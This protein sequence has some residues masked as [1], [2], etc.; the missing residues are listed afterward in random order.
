MNGLRYLIASSTLLVSGLSFGLDVSARSAIVIDASSGKVLWEKN[1][2][3]SMYPA[4]TTKIMTGLLL[5]EHCL[6]SDVITAPDDVETVKEASMH[7]RPGERVSAHDMLYAIMLRSANDGCYAIAKHVSG[8]VDAFAKLMNDRARQ[9]GCTNTHFHNPNGLNDSEHTTTAHDLALMARAAM[10]YPEF[11]EAVRTYKYEITRSI[12]MKDRVMV[13]HDKWLK[14]DPTADGVKTGYTVP[15]GHCFVGSATRNGFRVITVVMK[16]DHWQ[17]DHQQ[18]LNWAFKNF[19]KKEKFA[20]GSIVGTLKIPG[21]DQKPITVALSQ[22]A[23]TLGAVG[24]PVTLTESSVVPIRGLKA[25]VKRGERVGMLVLKDSD[26]WL[27]KIPVVAEADVKT[28][29]S[30]RATGNAIGSSYF[31]GGALFVGVVLVQGRKKRKI[32]N[33]G[34]TTTKQRF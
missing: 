23:Y 4:S 13:N 24:K 7:L 19:E 3:S 10:M 25:P 28:V 17:E 27:Q 11:R 1:S 14:K 30:A 21:S 9:V 29:A 18:L 8:S 33:Y 22:D 5:V 26:G 34:R 32:N 6:P 15:A 31:F 12:N 16:S 2:N 20:Q